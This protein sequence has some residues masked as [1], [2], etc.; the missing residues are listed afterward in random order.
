VSLRVALI[1]TSF[2]GSVQLPGFRLVDGVEVVAV[3]SGR[4][5][6]AQAVASKFGIAH[7]FDD[8]RAMLDAVP[9][10]LISIATPPYLHHEM[11]LDAARRGIHVMCEKPLALNAAQAEEMLSAAI[12][13][14]VVHAVDFEF[15]FYRGLAAFRVAVEQGKLGEARLARVVWRS[16]ARATGVQAP[17]SWW[18]ERDRGGG[19]LGAVASHWI[20]A[21]RWWFGEPHDIC[22]HLATFVPLRPDTDGVERR[23][24]TEDTAS[25]LM[26]LGP[27][28]TLG[29]IDVS[30]TVSPPGTRVEA[31]GTQGAL[32]L[33]GYEDLRLIPSAGPPQRVTLAAPRF[34]VVDGQPPNVPAFAELAERV[35]SA[36]RGEGHAEFPTFADGLA[37]QRVLDTAYSANPGPSAGG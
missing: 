8:Y 1:G 26:R 20:D 37:V 5:E 6:H 31:Y 22:A 34:P 9:V 36:I 21:L 25:L 17:Y 32:I 3:A 2:G 11:V 15:R 18:S 24:S 10:D 16:D 23:V 4:L 19:V 29:S 28:G 14:G 33:E 7:A 12:S 35:A 27:T 30:M 13:N